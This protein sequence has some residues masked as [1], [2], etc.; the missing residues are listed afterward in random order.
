MFLVAFVVALV[1]FAVFFLPYV[2]RRKSSFQFILVGLG[3]T[4]D[5]CF[6]CS[7]CF[8]CFVH[9]VA[10]VWFAFL[11]RF[12]FLVLNALE[13]LSVSCGM[14]HAPTSLKGFN[15]SYV[16]HLHTRLLFTLSCTL[17]YAW[18]F[19]D[20][21]LSVTLTSWACLLVVFAFRKG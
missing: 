19:C 1:E 12:L 14:L 9:F 2:P 7:M 20:R 15:V 10:F 21:R 18:G 6:P 3:A 4:C 13:V 16:G 8:L 5:L 11:L 17:Y